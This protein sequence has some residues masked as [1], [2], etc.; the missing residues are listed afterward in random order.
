M[1]RLEAEKNGMWQ[2]GY[3]VY[4]QRLGLHGQRGEREPEAESNAQM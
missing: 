1:Q 2:I 4:A 3:R